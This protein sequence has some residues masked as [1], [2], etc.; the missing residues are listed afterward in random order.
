M[1]Y[2]DGEDKIRRRMHDNVRGGKKDKDGGTRTGGNEW[3]VCGVVRM[4]TFSVVECRI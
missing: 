1:R 3:G 2:E 4:I